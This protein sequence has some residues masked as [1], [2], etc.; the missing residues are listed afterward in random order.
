MG[1][2]MEF[3]LQLRQLNENRVSRLDEVAILQY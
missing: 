2:P 1:G 3:S